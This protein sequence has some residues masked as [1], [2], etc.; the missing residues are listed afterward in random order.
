MTRATIPPPAPSALVAD[1]ED[2]K[3]SSRAA[4]QYLDVH[5]VTLRKWRR[6]GAGP[7]W[8]VTDGGNIRYALGELRRWSEGRRS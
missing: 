7:A 4:A 8:H 1:L 5:P 3:L 2:R 6:S